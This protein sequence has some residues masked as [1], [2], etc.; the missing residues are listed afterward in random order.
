MY[1]TTIKPNFNKLKTYFPDITAEQILQIAEEG[2]VS[3]NLDYMTEESFLRVSEG[4]KNICNK[5]K[6][7]EH[8]D[9]LLYLIMRKNEQIRSRYDAYW[10]NYEDDQTSKEVAKF[11]LAFKESKPNHHFQLVAKP[12]T[13]SVA[14]KDSGIAKWMCEQIYN[15]IEAREYPLG[16]FGEKLSYDLFG[17]EGQRG[18]TLSL[19]R[20]RATSN[21]KPRK[22]TTKVNRLYVEFCIYLQVYLINHTSLTAPP[23]TL[24]TDVQAN[25]FFDVLELIGY[26]DRDKVQS[27]PKDYM[28]AMFNNS[29]KLSS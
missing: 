21:L 4:F 28:H 18:D 10:Q 8:Y 6:V 25:F 9:E 14:I 20:L 15:K 5:Y 11:L 26:L 1:Q 13:G 3:V 22:P 29:I 7:T 24:L 27:E 2:G 19:E 16:L 12:I 23:E 17:E